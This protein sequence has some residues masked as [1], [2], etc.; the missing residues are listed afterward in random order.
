MVEADAIK[1]K[2]VVYQQLNK[3]L[4]RMGRSTS[5]LSKYV[6][7]YSTKAAES[8]FVAA[9]NQQRVRTRWTRT[10]TWITFS[11]SV[12]VP[13]QLDVERGHCCS[14]TASYAIKSVQSHGSGSNTA[15]ISVHPSS[16]L[17]TFRSRLTC[18]RS[19]AWEEGDR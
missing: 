1:N 19:R 9:I 2:D 18:R 6:H 11:C 3:R 17:G 8:M 7:E 15:E 4:S 12:P 16:C 10:G 13:W 14:L 5:D